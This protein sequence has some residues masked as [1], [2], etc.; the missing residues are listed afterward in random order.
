MMI[1]TNKKIKLLVSV[2]LIFT[3]LTAFADV[4]K[5][6]W[7]YEYVKKANDAGIMIG[8]GENFH[9]TD[10]ISK[11][12]MALVLYRVLKL[13]GEIK[14]SE[15]YTEKY[16]DIISKCKIADWAAKEIA[17]G[18]EYG[19]W[20]EADFLEKGKGKATDPVGRTVIARWLCG[21]ALYSPSPLSVLE[22]TDYEK[23]DKSQYEYLDLVY[24]YGL[25]I[26]DDEKCFLPNN[27][28]MRVEAATVCMRLLNMTAQGQYLKNDYTIFY[29]TVSN[30]NTKDGVF[31]MTLADESVKHLK[32]AKDANIILNGNLASINDIKKLEG[33]KLTISSVAGSENTVVAHTIATSFANKKGIIT[34]YEKRKDYTLVE[35]NFDGLCVPFVLTANTQI[36]RGPITVGTRVSIICDGCEL[37]EVKAS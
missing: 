8:D 22:F 14:S 19:F 31:D 2:L 37:W 23:V 28:T 10:A 3:L 27:N 33:K 30:V 6:Y 24:R 21:A 34:K 36:V 12:E 32:I 11:Q 9:P 7:G 35:I 26:G 20:T 17:Y 5:D 29:G 18:F 15:D 1:K 16:S 4:P 13:H 25:M